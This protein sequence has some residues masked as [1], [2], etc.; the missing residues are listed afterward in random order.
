MRAF[1][2]VFDLKKKNKRIKKLLKN[3]IN[4]IFKTAGKL[5]DVEIQI[6][7]LRDYENL[8]DHDYAELKKNLNKRIDERRK[9][10][11]KTL[12][13]RKKDFL[14]L[15]LKEVRDEIA[16]IPEEKITESIE[17]FLDKASKKTR[18][19]SHRIIPKVL[20]KQRKLLKE[21]RFCLEMTDLTAQHL[22]TGE[23][24]SRIKEIEDLLGSWHDY[25]VLN[26]TVEKIMQKLNE[27][28]VDE[29]IKLNTLSQ[30]VSQDIIL[31]LDKYCKT[32][33]ELEIKY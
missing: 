3:H 18:N 24:I 4:I 9:I 14:N 19:N 28:K 6:Y 31:L 2:K 33:P 5:R 10:L 20:H 29:V 22:N 26:R 8:L 12:S 32:I 25:N 7:L 15:L 17:N 30:T 23:Q 11:R 21:I 16:L 27:S 13:D 1:L